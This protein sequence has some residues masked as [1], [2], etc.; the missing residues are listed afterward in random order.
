LVENRWWEE[1]DGNVR[2]LN[3]YAQPLSTD[4]WQNGPKQ[5]QILLSDRFL[6]AINATLEV[7]EIVLPAGEWHAIPPFA[8]EDNPVITA[9]WQGP[10][11]GLCVFQR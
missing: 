10:A 2:W 8:G 3:R 1:G 6:I 7:T 5:L 4:E 11:H 9:V